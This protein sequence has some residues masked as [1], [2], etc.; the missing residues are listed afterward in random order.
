MDSRESI[1]TCMDMAAMVCNGYVGDL[2]DEQLMMRPHEGCNHINWQLGHLIASENSIMESV[3]PG[4]MPALPDGFAEKYSKETA[5]SDDAS[6]FCSKDELLAAAEAQRKGTLSILASCS[7]DDLSAESPES[8][9][10]FAPTVGAACSMQGSH[11]MMHAGQWVIVR[12][13]LG[14]PALF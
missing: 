2:T 12:R 1:K 5:S 11:W 8:I 14:K 3:K 4:A 7:D 10:S 9:R 13:Q 6:A